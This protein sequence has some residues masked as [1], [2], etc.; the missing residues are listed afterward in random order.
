[1][2]AKLKAESVY[3]ALKNRKITHLSPYIYA[4]EKM[5]LKCDICG[6]TWKSSYDNIK[7]GRSC[8]RCSKRQAI[9]KMALSKRTPIDEVNKR[10]KAYEVTVGENYINTKLET[11]FTCLR[12]NYEWQ[13]TV[14][15]ML[16]R[17]VDT[18]LCPSEQLAKRGSVESEKTSMKVRKS[19][20]MN[21]VPSVF[22]SQ[23]STYAACVEFL[24]EDMRF[25]LENNGGFGSFDT[26]QVSI[27]T[28][29]ISFSCSKG[30][31]GSRT[32]MDAFQLNHLCSECGAGF[33]TSPRAKRKS[34]PARKPFFIGLRPSDEYLALLAESN[35][36]FKGVEETK[37]GQTLAKTVCKTCRQL[38]KKSIKRL[39]KREISP[40]CSCSDKTL[41]ESFGSRLLKEVNRREGRLISEVVYASGEHYEIQCA[42]GHDPWSPQG[43][44]VV[45]Q[46][47][48]C[49]KCAGNLP[50]PLVE[51]QEIIESRGGTL[52]STD[53]RGVDG[54]YDYTCN[55][56]HPNTNIWKKIEDGQWCVTCGKTSKSEEIARHVLEEIFSCPFPKKRPRWLRN[57]RGRQME[58][59][60]YAAELGLAFEY[61]G[62]QHFKEVKGWN[63]SLTQRIED[64]KRKSDLCRE[65]NVYLII[66]TYEQDYDDFPKIIKAQMDDF[67]LD[68]KAYDFESRVDL[69]GAYIR[70]NRLEELRALL[71]PKRIEV[72]STKW[73]TSGTRYDLACLVCGH[74]WKA[75][76]HSF[77]NSRRVS[78]CSKCSHAARS[79][80]SKLGLEPLKQYASSKGGQL[81]STTYSKRN[82]DYEW[83]CSK[84]HLFP[85]N[86]NNMAHRNQFCPQCEK[87]VVRESIT[88]TSARKYLESRNLTLSG[89]YVHKTKKVLIACNICGDVRSR[90]LKQVMEASADCQ[91]CADLERAKTATRVMLQAGVEPLEPYKDANTNWLCRCVSCG[92]E[93]T[94]T[95]GNVSRGQGAC[96]FCQ[97]GSWK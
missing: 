33:E 70:D 97:R 47:S 20:A 25:R 1:M 86:F 75:P 63:G 58:L 2:P 69:S 90:S 79:E 81:V 95:L 61:Q 50:R 45:Y 16:Q 68:T 52:I 74:E 64:D 42:E 18:Y 40:L 59:D 71:M 55:L 23:F 37:Q 21:Q 54:S 27:T 87:R 91:N 24:I 28:T 9:A 56:G 32:L 80:Q 19:R 53:N 30:H 62:V 13:D 60:G 41:K 17:K 78:G 96:R 44:S 49:P 5:E 3:A 93:I 67:G 26:E 14:Q 76:G 39:N 65:N 10:L 66:L 89:P 48:W 7:Q 4:T 11:T 8:P 83:Q 51:L 57:S 36:D 94:P 88:E 85:G 46:N 73:L 35:V 22:Q 12:C 29:L 43:A 84:G 6:H 34:H 72:L 82:H 31:E 77:F 38:Y 92:N 15:L